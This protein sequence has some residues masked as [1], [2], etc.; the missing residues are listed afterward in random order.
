[1]QRDKIALIEKGIPFE[2]KNEDLTN[3]TPEYTALYMSLSADEHT[4]TK[5]PLLEHGDPGSAD[6]VKLIESN[7]ILDYIEDV[8]GSVGLRLRPTD[9]KDAAAVRMFLEHFGKMSP[10]ALVMGNSQEVLRQRL[11][12][13]VKGMK[14]VERCMQLY[15]KKDAEGDFLLGADFSYAECMAAPI[16]VRGES[17]LKAH[18]GVDVRKL[19]VDLGLT[20]LSKWME[21]VLARP[22]VTQTNPG[23][24]IAADVKIVHPEWFTC[25]DKLEFTVSNGEIVF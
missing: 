16:L 2:A 22:S 24:D 3:R 25:E 6:Y 12:D 15:K 7:V 10:F 5:V 21:A 4:T 11:Q 13:F 20:H 23:G 17:W 9:P 1:V 18:H 19:A 8:W 14:V